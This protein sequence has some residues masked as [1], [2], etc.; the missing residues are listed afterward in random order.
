MKHHTSYPDTKTP[1]TRS[2]S[3]NDNRAHAT[4][5]PK[6]QTDKRKRWCGTEAPSKNIPRAARQSSVHPNQQKQQ[7]NRPIN[8]SAKPQTD[9]KARPDTKH[10]QYRYQENAPTTRRTT[11]QVDGQPAFAT[12]KQPITTAI[13]TMKK[14]ITENVTPHKTTSKPKKQNHPAATRPPEKQKL[15]TLSN[16]LTQRKQKAH[17]VEREEASSL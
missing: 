5:S 16:T 1:T 11:S 15:P 9:E 7:R 8:P 14:M 17:T 13:K 10:K 6:E 3:P 4:T 2:Y 12:A